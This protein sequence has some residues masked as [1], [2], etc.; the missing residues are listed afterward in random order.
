MPALTVPGALYQTH[1]A[2][3]A[4]RLD[5]LARQAGPAEFH[6]YVSG[7]DVADLAPLISKEAASAEVLIFK[8]P[9]GVLNPSYWEPHTTAGEEAVRA[10]GAPVIT[11]DDQGASWLWRSDSIAPGRFLRDG[12][13]VPVEKAAGAAFKVRGADLVRLGK[14]WTAA[15]ADPKDR[16]EW[17]A[18]RGVASSDA[19]VDLLSFRLR[20]PGAAM[21]FAATGDRKF[22]MAFSDRGPW[23]ACARAA[24]RGYMS[25][26]AGRAVSPP[27]D[28]VC[29]QFLAHAGR[30]LTSIPDKDF[31]SRGT[32]FEFTA[33]PGRSPWSEGWNGDLEPGE[34]RILVYYDRV[35]GIW[36]VAS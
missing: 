5:V 20:T 34:E 4:V 33:W 3:D 2:G 25:R 11:R 15:G 31:I 32:A 16:F 17:V 8:A 1:P 18:F 30:G 13:D 35:A 21:M 24:L 12:I 14:A 6:F 23:R 10:A 27:N 7:A 28:S 26:C 29:D 19:R 36:A 22:R 9:P